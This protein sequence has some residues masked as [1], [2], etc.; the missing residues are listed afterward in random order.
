MR[1]GSRLNYYGIWCTVRAR[2]LKTRS[3]NNLRK[4]LF[5]ILFFKAQARNFMN[6]RTSSMNHEQRTSASDS[7]S[8]ERGARVTGFCRYNAGITWSKS[9]KYIFYLGF[10]KRYMS[11]IKGNFINNQHNNIYFYCS[12]NLVLK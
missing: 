5:F 11:S 4:F 8:F 9:K 6:K 12:Y 2:R 7:K 3:R 1:I 10:L